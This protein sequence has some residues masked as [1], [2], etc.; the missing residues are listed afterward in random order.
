MRAGSGLAFSGTPASKQTSKESSLDGWWAAS[1]VMLWLL[2][3]MLCIVVV[4]LAR[5]IGTLHLRLGPR[6]ALEMDAEGPA[7]G[8]APEAFDA[9]DLNGMPA[10]LGGPGQPQ[11]LVF[12]SPG[13]GTCER[14]L[15]SV[16][17][18]AAHAGL[19]PYVIADESPEETRSQFSSKRV[20]ARVVPGRQIA[21]RYAIPGTPFVVVLDD[22][23]VV[24][25]KGTP[26][27]LEQLEGL[28]DTARR[29]TETAG[30]VH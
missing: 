23:G 13:C 16:G 28:L 26:N 19:Q 30:S 20:D 29:R 21:R 14:L 12:V 25:A 11:M 18:V 4:A 3:V 5:Q 1:Y 15:P 24:R 27:N 9:T 7:L 17:P 8:E 22:L 10:T 2:V 6:G